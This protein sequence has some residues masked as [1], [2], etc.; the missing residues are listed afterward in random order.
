M[1]GIKTKT[2]KIGEEC[3]GGIIT[4]KALN[5]V[6]K[7]ELKEWATGKILTYSTFGRIHER[8]AQE[9][10]WDNTSDYHAGKVIQWAK[11]NAWVHS[12]LVAMESLS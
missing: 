12:V 2:W 9:W 11:E 6:L 10:L 1:Q 8:H 5:G 3:V 7:L 4:A